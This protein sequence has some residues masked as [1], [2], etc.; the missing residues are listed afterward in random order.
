MTDNRVR[1]PG[2][3]QS[4]IS[5]F[6]SIQEQV[7]A[8]CIPKL[9]L[10]EIGS[11]KLASSPLPGLPTRF[12]TGHIRKLSSG[13]GLSSSVPAPP[14]N[15]GPKLSGSRITGIRSWIALTNELGSVISIVQDVMVSLLMR[16]FHSS[17]KPAKVSTDPFR[18]MK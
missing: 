16:S 5:I 14:D 1:A 12:D 4:R 3:M 11:I 17:H 7:C 6:P 10:S 8:P 15:H 13:A 9:G 18:G 2:R